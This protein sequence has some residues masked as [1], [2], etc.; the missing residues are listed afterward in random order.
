MMIETKR[1]LTLAFLVAAF[2]ACGGAQ[3]PA[4]PAPAP[5][6]APA[7]APA[8]APGAPAAETPAGEAPA[9]KAVWKDMNRDQRIE[10]MKNVVLPKMKESFV[11]FD[12][13]EFAKMDCAT[14]HGDGAKNGSFKMPNPA[15]PK[16]STA[17]GF[18]KHMD[19]DAATTKFMMT[20]VV[21]EMAALLD[22]QPYDPQTHQGFGC[23]G[24][25][26]LDN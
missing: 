9:A 6:A 24:C 12:A 1:F 14:C 25:H 13:K 2:V 26:Q 7:E 23:A 11:A 21:P 4:E 15:L 5:P 18:K 16:L 10:H 8:P 20:K 22:T 3:P 19:H 17:N